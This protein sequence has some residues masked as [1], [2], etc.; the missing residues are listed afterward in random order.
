MN[1][2]NFDPKTDETI[3]SKEEMTNE[4]DLKQGSRSTESMADLHRIMD[5]AGQDITNKD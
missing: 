4:K 2:K 5:S 3:Q 1:N